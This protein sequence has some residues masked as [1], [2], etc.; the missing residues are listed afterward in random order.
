MRFLN[1]IKNV[2]SG[3]DGL[4]ELSAYTIP[5]RPRREVAVKD[6]GRKATGTVVNGTEYVDDVKP[7]GTI[8]TR[9]ANSPAETSN[10]VVLD[11]YDLAY[12]NDRIGDKW[13]KKE[14]RAKVIKWFWLRGISS[15]QI[16]REKTDKVTRK[17][18][19]GYSERTVAEYIRAYYEAD[20]ARAKAGKPRQ[21]DRTTVKESDE[22]GGGGNVVEW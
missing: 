16:E 6:K 11:E 7:D 15:S 9:K 17:L 3:A 8:V 14:S 10:E 12:L 21:R 22:V 2:L 20:D 1:A 5:E 19:V 4:P 13:K 18:E